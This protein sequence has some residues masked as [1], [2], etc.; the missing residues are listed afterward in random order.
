MCENQC[1]YLVCACYMVSNLQVNV[2]KMTLEWRYHN[3]ILMRQFVYCW[4][5][6]LRFEFKIVYAIG[7]AK[8]Y[9]KL[10]VSPHFVFLEPC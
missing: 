5:F 7:K 3:C 10:N 1:T 6:S 8:E 4:K 2:L 9:L